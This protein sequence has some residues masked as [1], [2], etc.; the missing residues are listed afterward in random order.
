MMPRFNIVLAGRAFNSETSELIASWEDAFARTYLYR[1]GHGAYYKYIFNINEDIEEIGEADPE[2]ICE[3][4]QEAHKT[5]LPL[6]A[7]M[8]AR[9]PEFGSES[10]RIV[11][12]LSAQNYK[13]VEDSAS[14][15]GMSTRTYID[16][17]LVE[18]SS[19]V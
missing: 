8:F 16:K 4:L 3:C 9:V 18:G 15:L 10:T 17:L 2:E 14:K 11:T 13:I 1:S 5:H 19:S 12:T 7:E 6:F